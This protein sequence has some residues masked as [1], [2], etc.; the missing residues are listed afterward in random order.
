MAVTLEELE[1]RVTRL[2]QE[3][4]RLQQL[5]EEPP[6]QETPAERGA[7]LLARARR[8]K[9]R[10]KRAMAR[11]LEEMGIQGEPVSPEKL[12]EMMMEGGVRPEDNLFSTGIREMREE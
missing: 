10:L 1:K 7:R 12:R 11:A 5:Q 2:E 9:P 8:D 6:P 3:L 4:D